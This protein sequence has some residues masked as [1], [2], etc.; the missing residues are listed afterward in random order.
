MW[1][2]MFRY[3]WHSVCLS[4]FLTI[5]VMDFVIMPLWT[6]YSNYRLTPETMVALAIKFDG[7]STQIAALQMLHQARIWQPLTLG[8]SGIFFMAFGAI[9]GVG[10]WARTNEKKNEK[11]LATVRYRAL[12][13]TQHKEKAQ[14]RARH[15]VV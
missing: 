7:A 5:T 14:T 10:A 13:A 3:H 15:A 11:D 2:R 12:R 9:L 4:V 6:E 8:E 1:R